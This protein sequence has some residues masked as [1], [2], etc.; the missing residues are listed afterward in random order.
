M[1]RIKSFDT[2]ET[3]D[4]TEI[5]AG[6]SLSPNLLSLSLSQPPTRTPKPEPKLNLKSGPSTR[7]AIQITLRW[8]QPVQKLY[9][10]EFLRQFSFWDCAFMHLTFVIRVAHQ[11]SDSS[12]CLRLGMGHLQPRR[13]GA[14]DTISQHLIRA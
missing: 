1:N 3:A 12:Q 5:Q 7:T 9:H 10:L 2:I 13:A 6:P 14:S 4:L 8:A 11:L